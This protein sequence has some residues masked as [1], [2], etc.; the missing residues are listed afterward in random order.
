MKMLCASTAFFLFVGWLTFFH[1]SG[2]ARPN[3]FI[4]AGTVRGSSFLQ[5]YFRGDI[6]HTESTEKQRCGGFL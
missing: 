5:L 1:Y 6:F 2:V 4:Q 3:G